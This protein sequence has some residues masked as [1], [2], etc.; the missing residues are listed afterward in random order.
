M[1]GTSPAHASTTSGTDA[2]GSRG[3]ES[4]LVAR[5]LPDAEARLDVRLGLVGASHCGC[6]CLPAT[7]TL[8][9]FCVSNACRIT[10][11]SVFA[12]GGR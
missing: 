3:I 2:A 6:G 5:P 7:T 8:T 9:R 4:G 10:A 11:S 1:V 12:S